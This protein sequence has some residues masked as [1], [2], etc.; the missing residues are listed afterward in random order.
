MPDEKRREERVPA[1]LRIRLGFGSIDEF[2]ERYALNISRGGIF[3]RT[4]EP[5]PSGAEVTLDVSLGTGEHVI[6]GRGVVAWTTP[7]SAP[8]EPARQ[9]GMGIKFLSLDAESRALVDLVVAT[10][11]AEGRSDEPPRPPEVE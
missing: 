6:R 2:V 8:G 9:P 1:E 7:P 10:R 3:V 5:R 11:G 4:L